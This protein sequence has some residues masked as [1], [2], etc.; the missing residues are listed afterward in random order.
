M[1]EISASI[2]ETNKLRKELGLAPLEVDET[3]NKNEKGEEKYKESLPKDDLHAPAI[4]IGEVKRSEELRRKLDEKKEKRKLEDHFK[5]KSKVKEEDLSIKD[6]IK[7]IGRDQKPKEI[8]KKKKCRKYES[9]N[10]S[11]LQIDHKLDSFVKDGKETVLTLKDSNILD[12]EDDILVDMQ[13]KEEELI[14]E[15][16]KKDN[17][18]IGSF[19]SYG[20]L[21]ER[22]DPSTGQI[23]DKPILSQY[24]SGN[25][26]KFSIGENG[27]IKIDNSLIETKEIDYPTETLGTEI[28]RSLDGGI[29]ALLQTGRVKLAREYYTQEEME[30][31]K[32]PTKKKKNKKKK[33][34]I[35]DGVVKN[36]IIDDGIDREHD[37]KMEK[38]KKIKNKQKNQPII[39]EGVED[40]VWMEKEKKSKKLKKHKNCEKQNL[41]EKINKV[42]HEN[43]RHNDS[44]D[45]EESNWTKESAEDEAYE[46]IQQIFNKTIRLR[47]MKKFLDVEKIIEQNPV[48]EENVDIVKEENF[49][50]DG[51]EQPIAINSLGEY[52]RNIGNKET[53]GISGNREDDQLYE[54]DDGS[55]ENDDMNSEQHEEEENSDQGQ[56][57]DNE[58]LE[59]EEKALRQKLFK[60]YRRKR[61]KMTDGL[62]TTSRIKKEKLTSADIL[63]SKKERDEAGIIDED[64]SHGRGLL[65]ALKMAVHS[66]MLE[67]E[68]SKKRREGKLITSNRQ[69]NE[70]YKIEDKNRRDNNDR[71]RGHSGQS[72]NEMKYYKPDFKLDYVDDNGKF[73]NE[74]EAFRYLSH[75]FHGKGAGKKKLEMRDNKIALENKRSKLANAANSNEENSGSTM[76]KLIQRQKQLEQAFVVLTSANQMATK[77]E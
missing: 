71:R 19:T 11:G 56:S 20:E 70:N 38:M 5:Q 77:E 31:F 57:E 8:E 32:K 43:D 15:R 69:I 24:E 21:A 25:D 65:S 53:Y 62:S 47:Q 50:F 17:A 28:G 1:A 36:E 61:S 51:T 39:H 10:L 54:N 76:T 72:F 4:N 16:Q 26:E 13:L 22:Y 18:I 68:S 59:E 6:W 75:K 52:C 44:S 37:I 66:G 42:I 30:Q 60:K 64:T 74:K 46:E 67:K 41:K 2:E 3:N 29:T 40:N 48:K 7:F 33:K 73:M 12:N 49:D 27:K 14:K 63:F 9:S 35:L 58:L 23:K 45:K 55:S 34:S